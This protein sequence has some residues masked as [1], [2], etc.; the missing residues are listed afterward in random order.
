MKIF[1]YDSFPITDQKRLFVL[2][3]PFYNGSVWEDNSIIKNKWN[4]DSN[5]SYTNNLNESDCLFIAHPINTYFS[6][7]KA[8]ELDQIN[9][10][11]LKNNI[12]G[13]GFIS[14]D[15]GRAYPDY[16]HLKYFRMGGFK[17]QLSN[18]NLGFPFSLSDQFQRFYHQENPTIKDKP[19]KPVIGFCGHATPSIKKRLLEYL[20]FIKENIK[21]CIDS[22]FRKDYEPL[23]ASAYER[24]KLLCDLSADPELDC[25]F[26]QREKYRGGAQ[27]SEERE[28]TTQEYYDNIHNAD[29][30]VC[31]RGAGNFSVRLYETLMMGKIPIFVNTNCMLPFEDEIDWKK[32]VVW[33]AWEERK[34]IATLVKKFH[35][36][37]SNE[38][39]R[40]IQ[41]INRELWMHHLSINSIFG[42][43]SKN[44]KI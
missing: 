24:W 34:N 15:F 14:G 39:F 28:N 10:L 4:I 30:V 41:V 40:E 43:I 9:D 31:V 12:I 29:Y 2:V 42:Y 27:T 36:S 35:E 16:S 11:C 19:L 33:V 1:I 6:N 13:Y 25:L 8:S 23:F 38:E 37:I 32:H 22:P 26:I 21:R 7:K 3:R 20:K 44:S 5:I 18:K 17:R